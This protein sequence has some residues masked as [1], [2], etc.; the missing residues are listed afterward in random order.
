MAVKQQ[1]I[2]TTIH[3]FLL[4]E[5]LEQEQGLA[6][7]DNLLMDIGVDSMGMLRLVGFIEAEYSLKIEPQYFTIEYFKDI[8]A[9]SAFVFNL[10]KELG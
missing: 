1:D 5:V 3:R 4:D 7:D 9:I 8:N 10:Q 6:L 2:A